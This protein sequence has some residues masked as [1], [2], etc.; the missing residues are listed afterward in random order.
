MNHF[1]C[2]VIRGICDY[3]DTHKNMEWQGFAA[4]MAAG[5]AKDLLR[6]IPPG[7]VEAERPIQDLL[8]SGSYPQ[9][10]RLALCYQDT[11][12]GT[13]IDMSSHPHRE[14]GSGSFTYH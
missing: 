5:Y 6:Q 11:T 2:L 1:P 3:S 14:E 7:R 8:S 4:M 12:T 13:D 10:S 9:H